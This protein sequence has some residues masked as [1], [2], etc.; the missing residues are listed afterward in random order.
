MHKEKKIYITHDHKVFLV[1]KWDSRVIAWTT[2]ANLHLP[3]SSRDQGNRVTIN[4]RKNPDQTC[5]PDGQSKIEPR[6]SHNLEE[7]VVLSP[8]PSMVT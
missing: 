8:Q 7:A 1:E 3:I 5:S 6:N 2:G 4:P